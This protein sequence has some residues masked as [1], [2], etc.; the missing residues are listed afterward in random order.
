MFERRGKIR[1]DKGDTLGG[2]APLILLDRVALGGNRSFLRRDHTARRRTALWAS[3]WII[4]ITSMALFAAWRLGVPVDQ[5]VAR[6]WE[7]V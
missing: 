6:V 7:L 4:R 1:L 3:L 2:T 5:M